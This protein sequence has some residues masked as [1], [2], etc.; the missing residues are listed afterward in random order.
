[1]NELQFGV[2]LSPRAADLAQTRDN[3]HA[4]EAAGL[5]FVSMQDHPYA[6][7]FLDTFA[8]IGTL[9][10]QTSRIRFLTDVANLPL[11]PP[12]MLAKAAASLGLLPGGR[13]ELG[14]GAGRT[15]RRSPGSAARRVPQPRLS[16]RPKKPSMSFA[17][18]GRLG[19]PSSCRVATI[20]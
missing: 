15:G 18:C 12:Q 13:F 10:G 17:R 8:F 20:R 7:D 9:I 16:A 11:R 14:L 1:M 2:F 3:V 6:P 19:V 4:A 5:D